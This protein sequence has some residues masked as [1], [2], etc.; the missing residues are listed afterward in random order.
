MAGL[1][2]TPIK[3]VQTQNMLRTTGKTLLVGIEIII[4]TVIDIEIITIE[5]EVVAEIKAIEI[6]ITADLVT[7]KGTEIGIGTTIQKTVTWIM[8]EE[9][10]TKEATE[11][12][13]TMTK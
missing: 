2:E 4:K 12:T 5:T 3:I 6:V 7:G 11:M 13:I 8:R 1:I 10:L 9:T